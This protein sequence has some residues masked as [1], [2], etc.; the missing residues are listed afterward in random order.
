MRIYINTG[1]NDYDKDYTCLNPVILLHC[2]TFNEWFVREF[3]LPSGI[4]I[5]KSYKHLRNNV[6]MMPDSYF[7]RNYIFSKKFSSPPDS[8]II[9]SQNT[10]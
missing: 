8:F 5:K 3:V 2:K 4:P 7:I 9:A 1:Q 6:Y 10:K